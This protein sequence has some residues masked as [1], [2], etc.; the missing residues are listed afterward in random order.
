MNADGY[1]VNTP[2]ERAVWK[3]DKIIGFVTI[4]C[5]DM[6]FLNGIK[7]GFYLGFTKEEIDILNN[8][9]EDDLIKA[10]FTK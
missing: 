5:N 4:S 2:V 1:N 7:G 8:G 9:S 10:G 6:D 3:N